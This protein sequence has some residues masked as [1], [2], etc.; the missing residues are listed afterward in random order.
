MTTNNEIQRAAS[1]L[2]SASQEFFDRLTE[3]RSDYEI[4][5]ETATMCLVM[6]FAQEAIKRSVTKETF[7]RIV[8]QGWQM[9][10]SIEYAK[11]A[12]KSEVQ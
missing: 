1:E 8:E 6:G 5:D 11:A 9:A 7:F 4:S 3:I 2:A 10:K 12:I